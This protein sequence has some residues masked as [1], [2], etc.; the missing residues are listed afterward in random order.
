MS[1]ALPF[2]GRYDAP[3]GKEDMD[4]VMYEACMRGRNVT[5]VAADMN[6][7]NVG[8]SGARDLPCGERMMRWMGGPLT[9]GACAGRS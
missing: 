7:T 8:Q 5:S 9:A 1:D 3:C 6:G 2:S 4:F